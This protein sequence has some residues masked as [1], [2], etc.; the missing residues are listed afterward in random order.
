MEFGRLWVLRGPNIWARVPVIEVEVE[1]G[2]TAAWPADLGERLAER[3]ALLK[4]SSPD[5]PKDDLCR[6]PTPAHALQHV[7][8]ELQ[9]L[10]GS[11]VAFGATRGGEARP[12]AQRGRVRGRTPGP[13]LPGDCSALCLAAM[14]DRPFDLPAE[15]RK[16]R[17]LSYDVRLGP[18]TAAI[19]QA[20]R[21]RGIPVR[22]L[23]EASLVQLGHGAAGAAYLHRRDR[24]H[25]RH[26]RGHRPGQGVDAVAAP[27]CRR[28]GARWAGGVRRRRR[29]GGCRGDR[30]SRRRQAAYGNHG[31]G[32]ATNLTTRDAV[33]RAYDAA[34]AE[35]EQVMVECFIPGA[36]YR[37][38]VIDGQLV[39]AALREPA[40]VIGDGRSTIAQLVDEANR[41]PRRSDGH[42]TVLSCIK[43]DPV[44]LAVLAEQ[45]YTPESAPS[46]G[47]RVL[48]RRNGNLSTG[49][50]ATDVTDRVHP[51]C[52]GAGRRGGAGRRARHCG[53][54]RG[55]CGHH[56]AAG[57]SRRRR[58]RGQRRTGSADAPGAVSRQAPAGG[59]GHRRHA[60]LRGTDRAA[61]RIAAVTGVN[62]KT[63]T[64]RLLAHLLRRPAR[65]SA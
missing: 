43:L 33:V 10:A 56:T 45:G 62:G 28:S 31:R 4:G 61:C 44:A 12:V 2:E 1:L 40:H 46:A 6:A 25:R 35:S 53:R 57:R 65:S 17:E 8:L 3:L 32:V 29:L 5:R 42:A 38:L 13:R 51:E 34:R 60:L 39:A 52:R 18:S 41:D 37:L 55:D 16:L 20:A 48:I 9:C 30:S 54:R 15:V 59:R 36:D 58:G 11:D 27:G 24:P 50:T 47:V 23:N 19:V 14:R 21:R 7:R 22:R 64:T 49:G 63:T 26:R